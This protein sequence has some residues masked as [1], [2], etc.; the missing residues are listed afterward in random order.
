MI[1]M[2]NI[3]KTYDTGKVKVDALK[4][5]SIEVKKGEFISLMGP[6]GSGKTTLMNIMGCLDTPTSGDYFLEH[7]KVSGFTLDKLASVRN[8]KIGFVF[9]NFNLLPYATALENVELPMVF[10]GVSARQR[11]KRA[12][13]LLERVGLKERIE[14]KPTEL[15]GGEMQR[16]AIARALVNNPSILLADEPT[17]N[18]DSKSGDEI[19]AFFQ[20]LWKEGY[21]I[22]VITHNPEIAKLTQR[23]IKLKDG[24]IVNGS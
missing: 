17:G 23:T 14:H 9:Q 16:V 12:T 6:S 7:E 24:T 20:E 13:E 15:S 19:V 4:D 2:R 10:A 8:Q 11:K 3:E 22:L 21:T 18:L 1:E 5:I